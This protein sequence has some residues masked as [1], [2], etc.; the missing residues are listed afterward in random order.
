MFYKSQSQ[1]IKE[2]IKIFGQLLEYNGTGFE[3]YKF[4]KLI[5]KG[6][7]HKAWP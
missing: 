3:C 7:N 1:L 5:N 2:L 6:R 4:I